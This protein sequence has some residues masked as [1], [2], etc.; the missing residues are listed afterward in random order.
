MKY[1][2]ITNFVGIALITLLLTGCVTPRKNLPPEGEIYSVPWGAVEVEATDDKKSNIIPESTRRFV[3]EQIRAFGDEYPG[4]KVPYRILA[5]SGGGSRGAYGAGVLSGWTESGNRPQFDVVT[6]ISTGALMATAAYLGPEYDWLLRSFTEVSND[7]I[8]TSNG[9]TAWV[10]EESLYDTTPLRNMLARL[11][12]ENVLKAVADEYQKGRSLF[13]GTTN[14]DANVFTVW[15]M[16]KIASSDKPD[17]LRLYRDIL[18]ASAAFPVGFPPVYINIETSEGE[19]YQQMHIDGGARETVFIYD[20]IGEWEELLVDMGLTI[21]E[22]IDFQVYLLYNGTVFDDGKYATVNSSI[23]S[24]SLASIESLMRKNVVTSIYSIWAFALASGATMHLSFIPSDYQ[25]M[26][27]VL[28]FDLEKMGKLYE[29][30]YQQ[31]LN[32][33]NWLVQPPPET[34]DEYEE[35]LDIYTILDPLLPQ[36]ESEKKFRELHRSKARD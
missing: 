6:G 23:A 36:A 20:F 13:I 15:D 25:P 21:D 22:H 4:K 1:S 16:G 31:T 18:Q 17:K 12:D 24:I 30:G 10:S 32:N 8:Y 28:E 33:T 2:I 7:D 11:I 29:F 9:I 14:L 19:H 5:L 27:D 35:L 34:L 26:P 3:T